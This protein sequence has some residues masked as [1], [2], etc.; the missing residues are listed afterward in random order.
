MTGHL[1]LDSKNILAME[2]IDTPFV[3]MPQFT[4]ILLIL[5]KLGLALASS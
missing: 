1:Y 2:V 5:I 4:F 3:D